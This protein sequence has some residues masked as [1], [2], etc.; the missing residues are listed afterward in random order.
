VGN[1]AIAFIYIVPDRKPPSFGKIGLLVRAIGGGFGGMRAGQGRWRGNGRG[2]GGPGPLF[3][4]GLP[5]PAG[6]AVPFWG[7][8]RPLFGRVRAGASTSAPPA[9]S[10]PRP[11][12]G[13]CG[14]G[15]RGRR[16]A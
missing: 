5:G 1:G 3:G 11:G 15:R 8:L 9:P 13:R 12:A 16:S 10:I 2:L 14:P 6:R 7:R 4:H